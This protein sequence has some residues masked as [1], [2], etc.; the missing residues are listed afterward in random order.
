MQINKTQTVNKSVPHSIVVYK[1]VVLTEESQTYARRLNHWHVN[2]HF[3]S[4]SSTTSSM[5]LWCPPLWSRRLLLSR[6]GVLQQLR[7]PELKTNWNWVFQQQVSL[8]PMERRTMPHGW[9]SP[10][11]ALWVQLSC[12]SSIINDLKP[13]LAIARGGCWVWL[14]W[15]RLLSRFSGGRDDVVV[16]WGD[17]VRAGWLARSPRGLNFYIPVPTQSTFCDLHW[18]IEWLSYGRYD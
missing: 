17:W 14:C 15:P 9:L 3:Q 8:S 2:I 11:A 6:Q 16:E 10:G 7:P 18:I 12:C 5:R 4:D 1:R 13:Q